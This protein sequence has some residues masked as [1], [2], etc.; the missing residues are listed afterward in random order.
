LI[1]IKQITSQETIIVRHPVLREGKPIDSCKFD[2]DDLASTF[3]LGAFY[4]NQLTGVITVLS[5]NLSAINLPNHYQ[6]RGMAVLQE[7]QKKGIGEALVNYAENEIKKLK[8][9]LIWMNAR[10]VAVGFYEKLGYIIK[11]RE[12][13]VPQ[14]GP[15]FIMIKYL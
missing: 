5:N 4:K 10:I 1:T 2:S 14:V 12:F 13:D 15:H 3:H 9:N 7:F 11:G 8:G 6:I